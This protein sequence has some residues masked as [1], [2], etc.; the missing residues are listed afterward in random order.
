MLKSM[1]FRSTLAAVACA[2][3]FSVHAMADSPKKVEISAG[4]LRP[5]LLQ[6]SKAFSVELFYQPSQLDHFHTAGVRG[7]YTPEA[8][9]RLLL[10]GTPLEFRT[11]PSGAMMVIDPTAP[12]ATVSA[13]SEQAAPP[14]VNS[15]G[16]QSWG[17]LQ[18]AQANQG[19][20][21][22]DASLANQSQERQPGVTSKQ[23]GQLQEIVVT[24]QKREERLQD[25]PM[26]I[27][28]LSG[29]E[30]VRTQS[31]RFED[32]VAKVPGLTL[33]DS[34]SVASQ[35]V[36]RGITSGAGAINS[37][38]ASY[39]DETPYTAVGLFAG[40]TSIAPNLDTYDMQRIEVLRGPQG[41][42]YGANALAGILKFVTN[43]PDPSAFKAT[44]EAGGN[45]VSSG[46]NGFNA[47]AMVN[48]PLGDSTALRL[49]GYDNYYAGFIDDPSRGARDINGTHFTGGRASLLYEPAS[50][51]S[52]RISALYQKKSWGDDNNE[53]VAP[54]SLMPLYG[55]LVQEYLIAQPGQMKTQVY[56]VTMN[57]DAGWANL[58]S[59]TSYST[60]DLYSLVDYS[61]Q[62]GP[63]VSALFGKPYG[64]AYANTND[65]HAFSQEVRLSSASDNPLQWQVG[66]YFTNQ[67]GSAFQP[68]YPIDLT[69]KTVLFSDP[70]NFGSFSRP[71]VLSRIRGVRES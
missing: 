30:L 27:T 62:F 13:L 20:T 29:E 23:N 49:V 24:A 12:R 16:S 25:V 15:D 36:I 3:S 10:K 4:D 44:V 45:S 34:G 60:F 67:N 18:L 53:Y 21:A 5:A 68:F 32:Y 70:L 40:S 43:P 64:F 1:T 58:L 17:S 28:A 48:L 51:V 2:I 56:N 19:Q 6:L 54:G 52:I 71:S 57:W 46:G 41:T 39:I 37:A 7:S 63:L 8:A 14:P 26:G 9:V 33:L 47:H 38:V 61:K 65:L 66:G 11:D 50:N 69:T 42:L 59:T 31:Y 22:S 35:L 55:S